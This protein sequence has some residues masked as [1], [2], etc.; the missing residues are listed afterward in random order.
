MTHPLSPPHSTALTE[1][2]QAAF[3]Q[4]IARVRSAAVRAL[5]AAQANAKQGVAAN[6]TGAI[7]AAK[8]TE[9]AAQAAVHFVAQLHQGLDTVA[10]QARATGPQPACQAG[11]AHCCYL[12]V[13]AT[14]P[15][16]LRIAQ[17]LRTLPAADQAN[18]LQRLQQHVATAIA[19]AP[20]PTRQPC[21]FLA[22]D[23]CAI[24]SVR[25]AACR[26]AHSLSATHCA[27][28][29]PTIPQN[30]RLLVDAEALMAGTALAYRDQPL[31][32]GAHE[33]NAAVLAALDNTQVDQPS[34]LLRWYHGDAALKVRTP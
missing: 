16:V 10:E 9:A 21:S 28:Q 22:S 15:E 23:R 18:A 8:A 14:E 31:P 20:S 3:L 27:E 24:Y 12:R 13:E 30:L 19:A 17:H 7:T 6:D 2:E 5:R 26:K 34:A 25:P 33:L 1:A 29:S 32:A 4:S 11:C